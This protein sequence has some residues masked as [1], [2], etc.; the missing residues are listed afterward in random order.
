MKPRCSGLLR[1]AQIVRHV[2][3]ADG[4]KLAQALG[5]L[6][7][8][9]EH[10]ALRDVLEH[11]PQE[12]GAEAEIIYRRCFSSLRRFTALSAHL[13]IVLYGDD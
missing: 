13:G 12:L 4:C 10:L 9:G 3:L 8:H 7:Q 2:L 5:R 1:G 11:G 6:W